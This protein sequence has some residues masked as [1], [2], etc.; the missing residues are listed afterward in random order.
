MANRHRHQ[1]PLG[2]QTESTLISRIVGGDGEAFHE[3]VQPCQRS[4]YFAA[5]STLDNEAD[6]EEVTQEAMLKAFRNLPGFRQDS[7]FRTWLTRITANEALMRLRKDR[8]YRFVPLDE[9]HQ[10]DDGEC[11]PKDI[12]D[13]RETPLQSLEG[14]E[15]RKLMAKA[16]SSLPSN[17]RVVVVLRDIKQFSIA[18]TARILGVSKANVKTRLFRGRLRMRDLLAPFGNNSQPASHACAIH[19]R[20]SRFRNTGDPW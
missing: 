4:V 10:D 6:A 17:Y 14:S 12:A 7:T 3:L 1:Q 20:G 2:T 13:V 15:L 19:R 5:L 16:L 8:R 18:E 9:P 11:V